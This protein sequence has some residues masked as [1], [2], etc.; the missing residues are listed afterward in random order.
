LP[1]RVLHCALA[2]LIISGLLCVLCVCVCVCVCRIL[3]N[4]C[5]CRPSHPL[6]LVKSCR[7]QVRDRLLRYLPT[8][9]LRC[10]PLHSS[11]STDSLLSIRSTPTPTPT[12]TL[13][14]QLQLQLQSNSNSNSRL[15]LQLQLFQ[16]QLQLQTPNPNPNPNPTPTTTPR[17]AAAPLASGLGAKGPRCG[18]ASTSRPRAAAS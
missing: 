5:L 17:H 2:P 8:R 1:L 3:K 14:L 13:Q 18:S 15:Q 12:P 10:T 6:S 11:G 7:R 9:R 16:L 4:D